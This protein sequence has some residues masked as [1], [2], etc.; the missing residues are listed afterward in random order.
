VL[1]FYQ[2]STIVLFC[3]RKGIGMPF[4]NVKVIEGVFSPAQ[5]REMVQRLTDAMVAVEGAR[6]RELTWV[7]IEEVKS[8]DWA[9]GGNALSTADVRSL[10]SG[11]TT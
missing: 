1:F 9:V 6:M 5:K 7:V 10:A 11:A 8:G 2:K 4:V 3:D